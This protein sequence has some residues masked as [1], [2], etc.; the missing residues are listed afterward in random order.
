MAVD[1]GYRSE[2]RSSTNMEGSSRNEPLVDERF[3]AVLAED[4]GIPER[5]VTDALIGEPKT[6]AIGICGWVEEQA[7]APSKKGIVLTAWAKKHKMGI[8]KKPRGPDGGKVREPARRVRESEREKFSP[9]Q[10]M[11]NLERMGG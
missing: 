3:A 1:T 9:A 7:K 2:G 4:F 10:I 5:D 6:Q 11:A 8:Y